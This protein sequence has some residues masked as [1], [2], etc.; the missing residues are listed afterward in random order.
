[1]LNPIKWCLKKIIVP[2]T[3]TS[4]RIA[5]LGLKNN[6]AASPR[7]LPA[8]LFKAGSYKS[9][10]ACACIRVVTEYGYKESCLLIKIL[11]S[12]V[13]SWKRDTPN[14]GV[15][16]SISLLFF[17][18]NMTET[19]GKFY[20]LGNPQST[21]YLNFTDFYKRLIG[22]NSKFTTSH[23][24]CKAAVDSPI[25]YLSVLGRHWRIDAR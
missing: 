20:N 25:S 10:L 14:Y 4:S 9:V 3:V 12:F 8:G 24:N 19:N 21:G 5:I 2:T 23:A 18:Y 17:A 15:W 16:Y 1:M 11:I 6:K 22:T 7:G 13:L